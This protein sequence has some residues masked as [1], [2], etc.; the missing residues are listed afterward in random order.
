[1]NLVFDGADGES[2][3]FGDLA[4]TQGVVAA[5]TEDFLPFSLNFYTA[6]HTIPTTFFGDD[7]L[8]FD[9]FLQF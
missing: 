1:M 7:D 6:S 2:E 4:V 3:F 8:I 5:H 9:P